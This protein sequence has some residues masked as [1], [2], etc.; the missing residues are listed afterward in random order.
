MH[1]RQAPKWNVDVKTRDQLLQTQQ[2][3]LIRENTQLAESELI[4]YAEKFI[5]KFS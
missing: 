2:A 4:F 1:S 3:L 5:N